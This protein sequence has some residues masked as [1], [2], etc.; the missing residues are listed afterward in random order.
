MHHISM[1]TLLIALLLMSSTLTAQEATSQPFTAIFTAEG[2]CIVGG[3]NDGYVVVDDNGVYTLPDGGKLFDLPVK[4]AVEYPLGQNIFSPDGQYLAMAGIGLYA[5]ETHD[6]LIESPSKYPLFTPDGRF[7]IDYET[8]YDLETLEIVATLDRYGDGVGAFAIAEFINDGRW[9]TFLLS[10]QHAPAFMDTSTWQPVID[11][12]QYE[13]FTTVVFNSD[14]TRYAVSKHGVYALED[15]QK[16][17]DIPNGIPFFS[18]DSKRLVIE[19]P[20]WLEGGQAGY[21]LFNIYDGETGDYLTQFSLQSDI[22]AQFSG[23][24]F[25]DSQTQI[26][27]I[28]ALQIS[29]GEFPSYELQGWRLV[30]VDTGQLL[31]QW[32]GASLEP[33]ILELGIAHPFMSHP[34]IID[35][36]YAVDGGDGVYDAETH[37]QIFSFNG[38]QGS[39]SGAGIYAVTQY[40]CTVWTLP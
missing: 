20:T 8:V 14:F 39:L 21:D 26:A 35:G 34:T 27:L 33:V 32:T 1:R 2:T 15:G 5:L 18:A 16:L 4:S 7:Y 40:P 11:T 19:V 30:D 23:P 38:Q 25:N 29:Q 22:Y 28:D 17:F 9:L 37:Q 3:E 6:L 12:A 10:S 13:E 36:R 24:Y 31:K